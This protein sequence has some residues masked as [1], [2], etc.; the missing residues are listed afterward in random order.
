VNPNDDLKKTALDRGW[1][2]YQPVIAKL[3]SSTA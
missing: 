2:F 3:T 1:R